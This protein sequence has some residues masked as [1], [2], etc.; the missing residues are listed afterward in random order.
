MKKYLRIILFVLCIVLVTGCH[1]HDNLKF[2]NDYES[3]NGKKTTYNTVHRTINID[4]D[5]PFVYSDLKNINKMIKKKKTFIVYFGANWCPWCRSIL[6]TVIKEA[7]EN[8][9]DKIYYINVREGIDE[10]NDIRD[11]YDIDDSGNIYLSHKGL[12]EYSEF[13]KYADNVLNEYSSHGVEVKGT[14]YAGTKRVGAPSFIIVK[15]GVVTKLEE[16]VG[17]KLTDPYMELTDEIIAETE[18]I[19]DSFYKEY[20]S[21]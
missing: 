1:N 16:G 21:K 8:K 6:P 15:N 5:N 2:K 18:S 7:K 11:I 12:K 19:F 3:L 14:K 13:L 10:K 9:I 4:E 17:S 20:L